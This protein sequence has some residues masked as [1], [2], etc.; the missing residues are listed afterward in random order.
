MTN[1][2]ANFVHYEKAIRGPDLLTWQASMDTE[3]RRLVI[4]TKTMTLQ[5]NGTV[6]PPGS[7]TAT[8]NP[9]I[10]RKLDP[11]DHSIT[12]EFRTRMTWG[13]EPSAGDH[14]TSSSTFDTT[15]VKLFLN[16][17]V[18]DH[19][20]IVSTIDITDFYL[21]SKLEKPAYLWV[22]IRFLPQQTRD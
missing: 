22:P 4:K 19:D 8:A 1:H 12:T 21:N 18:S 2:Q 5:P 14:P 7:K 17:V 16:S 15:A 6:P 9:V 11:T 13:R 20:S 10:R 3:M